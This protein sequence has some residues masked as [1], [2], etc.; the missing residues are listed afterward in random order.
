MIHSST[1]LPAKPDAINRRNH[2]AEA[3]ISLNHE[4]IAKFLIHSQLLTYFPEVAF[5]IG[6][7]LEV[8]QTCVSGHGTAYRIAPAKLVRVTHTLYPPHYA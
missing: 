2:A 7:V 4:I 3:P 1:S 6:N 8:F 5:K